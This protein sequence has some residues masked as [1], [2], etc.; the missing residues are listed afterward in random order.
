MI[1]LYRV[2]CDQGGW[3]A[4]A[5]PEVDMDEKPKPGAVCP[6]CGEKMPTEDALRM[7]AWRKQRKEGRDE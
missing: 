5:L 4:T 2:S 6:T 7:R 3:T 1:A